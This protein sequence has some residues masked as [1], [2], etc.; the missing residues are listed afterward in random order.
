MTLSQ[1]IVTSTIYSGLSYVYAP[2]VSGTGGALWVS[3][4][5]AEDP[6][7]I[8]SPHEY[9]LDED[10]HVSVDARCSIEDGRAYETLSASAAG[11]DAVEKGGPTHGKFSAE[12][13]GVVCPSVGHWIAFDPRRAH[14][15][16]T[17]IP[18]HAGCEKRFSF[19]LFSPRRLESV[20]QGLWQT[21]QDIGFPCRDVRAA[22]VRGVSPMPHGTQSDETRPLGGSAGFGASSRRRSP[23]LLRGLSMASAL[24]Q[25]NALCL[26]GVWVRALTG[27]A[28]TAFTEFF[29]DSLEKGA[30]EPLPPL[31]REDRSRAHHG[32]YPCGLPFWDC[33]DRHAVRRCV[34]PQ[35]GRRLQRWRRTHR[36]RRMVN[37]SVA[38][39]S[40]LALGR[41]GRWNSGGQHPLLVALSDAQVQMCDGLLSTFLAVC[42]PGE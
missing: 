5:I 3:L 38:Y 40:W 37:A 14:G 35:S 36:A 29:L 12:T 16:T 21:L 22:C 7:R 34:P 8:H 20:D 18:E 13:L 31:Q 10:W 25:A 39:M 24:G 19:T 30:K 27:Q 23:S 11:F 9:R 28:P 41:P 4:D 2:S 6:E 17:F 33:Y 1:D 32:L 15:V 42:R 26:D